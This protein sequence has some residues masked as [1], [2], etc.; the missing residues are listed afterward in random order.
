MKD[1]QDRSKVRQ[2]DHVKALLT[3]GFPLKKE[4]SS[5]HN[6]LNEKQSDQE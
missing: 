6:P 1:L 3:Q 5:S 4:R 2:D